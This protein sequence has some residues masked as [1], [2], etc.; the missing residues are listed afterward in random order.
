CHARYST[1]TMSIFERVQPFHLLGH[2]GEFNTISRFRQEARQVGAYLAEGNS[3]SQDVDRALYTLV[4]DYGLDLIEAMEMVLPPV[5][6]EV[7]NFPSALRGVY[8]KLRQS[9]GPYA[10]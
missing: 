6:H 10:Q 4:V 2:N 1:N 7:E 3:D 8:T 5:P 9:Y